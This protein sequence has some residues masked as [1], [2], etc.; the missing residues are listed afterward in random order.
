MHAAS[1]GANL[2]LIDAMKLVDALERQ[3]ADLP[4]ALAAYTRERW[5]R[6]AFYQAQSRL[7]T[8][9]FA[10][11]S[12]ILRFLRDSFL[13]YGCHTP[14]L[15]RF[16]HAVLCGAQSPALLGT[17]PPDEFLGFLDGIDPAPGPEAEGR[18]Q[19]WRNLMFGSGEMGAK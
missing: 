6:V 18:G 1:S 5:T 10:S 16:M 19:R 13:Y 14:G 4:A 15:R 3:P 9:I 12:E 7:L 11:R 2:A 17:I 8:P